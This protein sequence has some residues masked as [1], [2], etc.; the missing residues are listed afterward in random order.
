MQVSFFSGFQLHPACS[1][2]LA[3]IGGRVAEGEAELERS[4]FIKGLF[5]WNRIIWPPLVKKWK[6]EDCRQVLWSNTPK[7]SPDLQGCSQETLSQGNPEPVGHGMA[8]F[9]ASSNALSCCSDCLVHHLLNRPKLDLSLR[10]GLP[11]VPLYA[12]G[13][14]SGSSW[15]DFCKD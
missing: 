6:L 15:H 14:K 10:F 12:G 13:A 4:L 2:G 7:A 5:W 8:M 9:L 1:W 11:G 3:R